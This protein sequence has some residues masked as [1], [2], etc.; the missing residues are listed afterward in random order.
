VVSGEAF[1]THKCGTVIGDVDLNSLVSVVLDSNVWKR[2]K[3]ELRILIGGG[4]ILAGEGKGELAVDE[5][6]DGCAE[7]DSMSI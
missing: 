5:T 1:D 6:G 4:F 2:A 7:S 3:L